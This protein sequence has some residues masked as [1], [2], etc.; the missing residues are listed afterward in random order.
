MVIFLQMSSKF[1]KLRL[2]CLVCQSSLVS[3]DNAYRILMKF[4][5][6]LYSIHHVVCIHCTG[7]GI[8]QST[9]RLLQYGVLRFHTCSGDVMMYMVYS[10][11]L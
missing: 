9:W 7:Y 5:R 10:T 8:A 6:T 11:D 2:G 1:A 4:C 3:L